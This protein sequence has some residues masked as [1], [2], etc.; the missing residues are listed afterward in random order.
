VNEE[1]NSPRWAAEPEIMMMIIIII[2]LLKKG[3]ILSRM[4]GDRNLQDMKTL[5]A[6][7]LSHSENIKIRN[8]SEMRTRNN[9]WGG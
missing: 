3:K 6:H 4:K 9:S 8:L 2:M 1:A 7:S 5:L